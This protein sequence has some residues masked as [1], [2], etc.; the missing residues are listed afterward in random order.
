VAKLGQNES[1]R[2]SKMS[3]TAN[4]DNTI[5]PQEGDRHVHFQEQNGRNAFTALD[6]QSTLFQQNGYDMLSS[7]DEDEQTIVAA[8]MLGGLADVGN[9]ET[10]GRKTQYKNG[11]QGDGTINDACFESQLPQS[12]NEVRPSP[13]LWEKLVDTDP[14]QQTVIRNGGQIAYLGESFAISEIVR[15]YGRYHTSRSSAMRISESEE[16]SQ[17]HFPVYQSANIVEDSPSLPVRS[18]DGHLIPGGQ[19]YLDFLTQFGC[20][21]LPSIGL[22]IEFFEAY[23]E[24]FH[25]YCSRSW[26]VCTRLY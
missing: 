6:G 8:H 21:D 7:V 23:F 22:Q 17:L 14:S 18:S 2:K 3:E 4:D 13:R 24:C 15:H 16:A 26:F 9:V 1:S 19:I 25:L 10:H 5:S 11:L 20:F 12:H